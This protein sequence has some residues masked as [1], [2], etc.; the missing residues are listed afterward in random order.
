MKILLSFVLCFLCG[1]SLGIAATI[2]APFGP[3]MFVPTAILIIVGIMV[4][5]FLAF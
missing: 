5:I 3:W 2:Q 1:L 4:G